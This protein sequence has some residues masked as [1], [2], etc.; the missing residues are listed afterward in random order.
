MTATKLANGTVQFKIYC[1]IGIPYYVSAFDP[2]NGAVWSQ[3]LGFFEAGQHTISFSIP[4]STL[5]RFNEMSIK[6][7][8]DNISS[9]YF[10][11]IGP[12]SDELSALCS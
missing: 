9:D 3:Y 11:F 6:F 7:Y 4:I 12:Y 10:M 8:N 5:S 1:T 2:P